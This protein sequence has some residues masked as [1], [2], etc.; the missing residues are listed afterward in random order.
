M[1]AIGSIHE[2]T[3]QGINAIEVDEEERAD[4][5][6]CRGVD[7]SR[8]STAEMLEMAAADYFKEIREGN[9]TQDIAKTDEEKNSPEE[10]DEFIRV[11]L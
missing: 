11:F 4:R 9:A 10:R 3:G 7:G 5:K 2:G 6:R 1:P 8:G